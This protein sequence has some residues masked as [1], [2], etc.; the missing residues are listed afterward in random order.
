MQSHYSRLCLII[1][2]GIVN[3]IL[4]DSKKW[5]IVFL[6]N[7]WKRPGKARLLHGTIA[8][9]RANGLHILLSCF[10]II[11]QLHVVLHSIGHHIGNTDKE[12]MPSKGSKKE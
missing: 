5:L 12:C 7:T 2:I 9:K 10:G 4:A 8:I 1:I 6:S 3:P 11:G